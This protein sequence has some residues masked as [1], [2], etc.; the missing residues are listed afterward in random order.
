MTPFHIVSIFRRLIAADGE[1]DL[2]RSSRLA[3]CRRA[4]GQRQS[5]FG[6]SSPEIVSS[7]IASSSPR[8]PS[9]LATLVLCAEESEEWTRKEMVIVGSGKTSSS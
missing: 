1:L 2:F 9:T 8:L 3:Y 4:D 7:E 6:L 5:N